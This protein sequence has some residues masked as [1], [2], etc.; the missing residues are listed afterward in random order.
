M[1][2]K[3]GE[4]D[5]ISFHVQENEMCRVCNIHEREEECTQGFGD[6]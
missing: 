2:H 1:T 3:A 6:H 4:N 5:I